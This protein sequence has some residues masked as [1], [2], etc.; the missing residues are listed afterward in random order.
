MVTYID[1]LEASIKELEEENKKLKE[2]Y[3]WLW[4][5]YME[6]VNER[7]EENEKLKEDLANLQAKCDFILK[8]YNKYGA[9][10]WKSD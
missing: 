8:L 10:K 6:D 4:K 7:I 2:K 5:I 1:D 9:V 3:Y